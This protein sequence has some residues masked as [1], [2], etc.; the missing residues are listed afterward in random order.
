MADP[1]FARPG[2]SAA[3]SHNE[4]DPIPSSPRPSVAS[5]ASRSSLR[6][7]RP[8]TSGGPLR[9]PSPTADPHPESA[10]PFTPLFTL[11][12]SNTHASPRHPLTSYIFADDDPE[13]LTAAL[14]QHYPDERAILIDLA[15]APSGPGYDVVR[16]SSLAPDWAVVSASVVGGRKHGAMMLQIEGVSVDAEGGK[17]STP[18]AE[19][20]G[21][22]EQLQSSGGS[23]GRAVQRQGVV[24]EYAA[25]LGDFEKRM[26]VL[27]RV[28]D[29][30]GGSGGGS[31]G[32]YG[33]E[34]REE[35]A[36]RGSGDGAALSLR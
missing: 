35:V 22:G 2:S 18:P 14:A 16:A 17:V 3:A 28:V 9:P 21:G 34:G 1:G 33:G 7:D 32:D 24:E 13:L 29:A 15:P 20:G 19:G 31:E 12:T 8:D 10:P 5:R 4:R 6:R 23:G 11:I 27:R 30:G 36:R 26:G 25:L